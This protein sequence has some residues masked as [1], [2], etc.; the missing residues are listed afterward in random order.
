MG[1]LSWRRE[2]YLGPCSER[3][4]LLPAFAEEGAAFNHPKAGEGFGKTEQSGSPP[5]AR[6]YGVMSNAS[7]CI[8]WWDSLAGW[9]GLLTVINTVIRGKCVTVSLLDICLLESVW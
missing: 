2:R 5:T 4:C 3:A 8:V 6:R 9:T 7:L 1:G